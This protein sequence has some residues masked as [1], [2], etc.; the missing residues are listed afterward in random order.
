MFVFAIVVAASGGGAAGLFAI[1][2]NSENIN[3]DNPATI[4]HKIKKA[5]QQAGSSELRQLNDNCKIP[6][7]HPF[8]S[9]MNKY[10]TL[11]IKPFRVRLLRY[12]KNVTAICL[13]TPNGEPR[14][15]TKKIQKAVFYY[16][17]ICQ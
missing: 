5:R 13:F 4:I 15:T 16:S 2:G 9:F 10:G 3:S 11:P 14:H 12:W 7:R 6:A 8:I 1:S 17:G